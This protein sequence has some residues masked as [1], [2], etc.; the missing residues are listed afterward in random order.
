[1]QSVTFGF[2]ESGPVK[3]K[4]INKYFKFLIAFLKNLRIHAKQRILNLLNM[5]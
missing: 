3:N 2:K 5:A 4:N 1:M